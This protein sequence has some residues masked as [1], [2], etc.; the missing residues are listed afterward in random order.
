[1]VEKVHI[2]RFTPDVQP[3]QQVE[4]IVNIP[5]Q[6]GRVAPSSGQQTILAF[7]FPQRILKF[8]S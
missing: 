7:S 3:E 8:D 4:V 5:N 1:M 6:N 2:T